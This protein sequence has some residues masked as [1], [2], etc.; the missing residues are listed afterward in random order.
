LCKID[1]SSDGKL[2]DSID[3]DQ[4]AL[5]SGSKRAQR[6]QVILSAIVINKAGWIDL[7]QSQSHGSPIKITAC[8]HSVAMDKFEEQVT[9]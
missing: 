9:R 1:H 4:C 6:R 2:F 5:S 8:H 7:S 3:I